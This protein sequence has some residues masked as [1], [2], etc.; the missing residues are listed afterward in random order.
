MAVGAYN[1][2][3]SPAEPH[4][5]RECVAYAIQMG[6]GA[7]LN[8]KL[9]FCHDESAGKMNGVWSRLEIRLRCTFERASGVI[10]IYV[11]APIYGDTV[12][13]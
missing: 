4:L 3:K 2:V 10:Y 7:N 12:R 9:L 5:C 11:Y 1:E 6:T 8:L 13:K